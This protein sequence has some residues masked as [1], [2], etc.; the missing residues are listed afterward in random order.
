M[1]DARW[2]D[3]T[4]AGYVRDLLGPSPILHEA[5]VKR[6]GWDSQIRQFEMEILY[7]DDEDG[8][9]FQSKLTLK[10]SGVDQVKLRQH[11]N[12]LY[13]LHCESMPD[14]RIRTKFREGYGIEGTIDADTLDAS[15]EA[16][17]EAFDPEDDGWMDIEIA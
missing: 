11:E 10:W 3:T 4:V 16:C 12:W 15:L 5:R 14:G 13:G 9:M 2:I 6:L 8:D 7:S 17:E 1:Q